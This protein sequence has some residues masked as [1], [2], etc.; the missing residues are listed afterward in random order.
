MPLSFPLK[1][2]S[3]HVTCKI[4]EIVSVKPLK[5]CSYPLIFYVSLIRAELIS[6]YQLKLCSFDRAQNA[7]YSIH[8]SISES[9]LF[10][11]SLH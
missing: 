8:S 2:F 7:A 10:D 6:I 4:H 5:H 11:L 1:V 9:M 3:V